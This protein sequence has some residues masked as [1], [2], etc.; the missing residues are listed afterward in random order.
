MSES[1]IIDWLIQQPAAIEWTVRRRSINVSIMGDPESRAV[2]DGYDIE[3]TTA[4][5]AMTVQAEGATLSDAWKALQ[6]HAA[7]FHAALRKEGA[8]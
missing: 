7:T 6:A 5:D 4:N 2:V 8:E 1:Q 3:I